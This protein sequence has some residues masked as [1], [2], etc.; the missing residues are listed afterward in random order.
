MSGNVLLVFT[1]AAAGRE[2]EFNSW[3]ED[4][5]VP[6]MLTVPGIKA[7]QRFRGQPGMRGEDPEHR[8]LAIYEVDELVEVKAAMIAASADLTM[9]DSRA[10]GTSTLVYSPITDWITAES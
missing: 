7:V 1:E 8:Y 4:V 9:S 10:P 5:H 3:Y 2:D 6:E